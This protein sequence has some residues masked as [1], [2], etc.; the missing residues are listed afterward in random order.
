[1]PAK[2]NAERASC[3]AC[4]D[5]GWIPDVAPL[6]GMTTIPLPGS[7]QRTVAPTLGA[8]LVGIAGG[9][10]RIVALALFERLGVQHIVV[11]PRQR[12]DGRAVDDAAIE[13][14]V[15]LDRD[16]PRGHAH[17]GSVAGQ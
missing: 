7:V 14:A 16:R 9:L 10:A 1:M 2:W 12:L 5:H 15:L 17:R 3:R 4:R 6:A 11:G 13:V 8:G